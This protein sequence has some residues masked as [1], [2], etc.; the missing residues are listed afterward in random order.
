MWCQEAIH[1]GAWGYVV[2]T[3][4]ASDLLP[5]VKAVCEGRRF[6]SSGL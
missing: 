3:K 4:A 1:L 6:V 5:A 2:K